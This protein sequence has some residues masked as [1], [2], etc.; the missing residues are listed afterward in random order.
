MLAKFYKYIALFFVIIVS[1]F[2]TLLV[3]EIGIRWNEKIFPIQEFQEPDIIKK[4]SDETTLRE[5][6]K[7]IGITDDTFNIYYFGESS[8]MGEPYFNTIPIM[9]EKMLGGRANGKEI[10]WIN[11]AEPGIDINEVSIRI[12]RIVDQKY[13]YFPSLIVIYEGHNEFLKYHGS[14]GFSIV[15]NQ[16]NIFSK[17]ISQSR[18]AYKIAKILKL[19]RLEIDNRTFFDTPIVNIDEYMET[20]Q[21]FKKMVQSNVSY[22]EK[23]KIPMIISTVAGNYADFDP[24]RSLFTGDEI[25]KNEFKKLMDLGMESEKNG[26]IIKALKSYQKAVD[27]D[28]KFAETQY[29]LGRVYQK[30]NQYEKA[31]K[32]YSSAVDNDMMP[33]RAVS[34]QNKS[35][36]E[37]NDN[38]NTK[39]IDVVSYLRNKSD[40]TLIGSN[41]FA[42]GHHPNLEGFRLI[43]ELFA[44]KIEEMYPKNT[45]FISL[46]KSEAENIFNINDGLYGVYLSRADW[47]IRLSS[48]R[49]DP[50]QRLRDVDNYLE[51]AKTICDD[52]SYWYLSKMTISYL[53][54]DIDEAKKYYEIANKFDPIVTREYLRN[55]WINQIITRALN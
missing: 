35:I 20:L 38:E 36:L 51:K 16:N 14:V 29:R 19:Y 9:I 40:N 34:F 4:I 41:F 45:K 53:K 13:I 15:D 50:S 39:V 17:I 52:D 42:D 3:L 46:S 10:K 49:Y 43:S 21:H 12:K 47:L 23:N 31:W 2:I 6:V 26:E 25:K 1:I 18:L 28:N 22:L 24:N 32:A 11:T 48:W 5:K 7:E 33:I 55:E 8:M 27:I 30:L 54:N 44:K 37:V